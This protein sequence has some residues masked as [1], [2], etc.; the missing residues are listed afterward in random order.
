M[1]IS[2]PL[3]VMMAFTNFLG[4][5]IIFPNRGESKLLI[6]TLI[7]AAVNL[8]LNLLL[9]RSYGQ[10]GAAFALICAELNSV[11]ILSLMSK[12]TR[13]EFP[14]FGIDAMRYVAA[15]AVSTAAIFGLSR[16]SG[17]DLL[18]LPMAS[19]AGAACYLLMLKVTGDPMLME[20]LEVLGRKLKRVPASDRPTP[21]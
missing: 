1:M 13:L 16:I 20:F 7:S 4:L 14:L 8:T 19:G 2:A 21:G 9:V 17:P 6:V 18:A 3:V 15:A 5:Q 12:G 10:N 11:F